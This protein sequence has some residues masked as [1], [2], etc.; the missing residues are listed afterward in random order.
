MPYNLVIGNITDVSFR[1]KE[2]NV[3]FSVLKIC[4][5]KVS[6]FHEYYRLYDT[7]KQVYQ[8]EAGRLW[9]VMWMLRIAINSCRGESEICYR[10]L[11]IPRD[12][13]SRKPVSVDLKA[14]I[15]GGDKDE[16][17]ITIMLPTE[18]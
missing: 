6:S 5:H 12:G 2:Q 7:Q 13:R 14:V 15:H 4:I 9:D 10:L 1:S 17:V 16:P 3:S 18:D 8:D 11:V